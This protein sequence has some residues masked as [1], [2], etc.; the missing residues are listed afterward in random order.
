LGWPP[1]TANLSIWAKSVAAP[2]PTTKVPIPLAYMSA[3]YFSVSGSLVFPPQEPDCFPSEI[4]MTKCLRSFSVNATSWEAWSIAVSMLVTHGLLGKY[5]L[6]VLSDLVR[7][8]WIVASV[9]SPT[10]TTGAPSWVQ[11]LGVRS[12][13]I[14]RPKRI[15]SL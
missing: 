1:A 13:N 11:L 9:S 4:S 14:A 10:G 8:F 3:M 5:L 7:M 12:G 2:K 6:A 15:L